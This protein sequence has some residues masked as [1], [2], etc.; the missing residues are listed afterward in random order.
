MFINPAFHVSKVK[1]GQESPLVPAG[2][3]PPLPRLVDG[4]LT[5]TIHSLLQSQRRGRGIQY[6]VDWEGYGPEER[7]WV[8]ASFILDTSGP[9]L[10]V[11][12]DFRWHRFQN[13]VCSASCHPGCG[14]VNQEDDGPFDGVGPSP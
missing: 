3:S 6:L 9:A 10:K 5:Y 14:T 13:A 12:A 1:L 4:E 7:S 2:P 11:F 8:P